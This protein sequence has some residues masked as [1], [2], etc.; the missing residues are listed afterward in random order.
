MGYYLGKGKRAG[1]GIGAFLVGT[2]VDE[3]SDEIVTVAKIGTG[4]TDEL[5]AELKSRLDLL[6]LEKLPKEFKI[7]KNLMPEVLVKPKLIVE[8]A[9]DEIT[10]SPIHS[11][12]VAL[13]FP[14]LIKLRD[15]KGLDGVTTLA[16]I[17]KIGG[18]EVVESNP[19]EQAN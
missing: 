19:D 1:F 14:R 2:R 11:A 10:K 6:K 16:E 7:D 5:F 4:I 8:I 12:G 3:E 17:K 13:R 9:A 18:I 15:D